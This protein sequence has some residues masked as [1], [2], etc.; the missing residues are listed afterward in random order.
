MASLLNLK[1]YHPTSVKRSLSNE[2]KKFTIRFVLS[3]NERKLTIH[4]NDKRIECKNKRKQIVQSVEEIKSE[5]VA[6]E[7]PPQK[8]R[9][10]NQNLK[11]FDLKSNFIK[12]GLTIND[13]NNLL[14]TIRDI[15]YKGDID[16]KSG[17]RIPF[18]LLFK[19]PPH[20][21]TVETWINEA[22]QNIKLKN[23][24]TGRLVKYLLG[25][26]TNNEWLPIEDMEKICKSIGFRNLDNKDNVRVNHSQFK[27]VK[28]PHPSFNNFPM[29]NEKPI[30]YRL[31]SIQNKLQ[32]SAKHK[33]YYRSALST[34]FPVLEISKEKQ[35]AR[36]HPIWLHWLKFQKSKGECQPGFEHIINDINF[37][38]KL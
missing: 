29:R 9:K 2:I 10:I 8:K 20:N 22:N 27:L 1:D 7:T 19:T 34:V 31:S 32:P 37:L 38:I 33:M 35:Y 23:T 28:F 36:L 26:N 16:N 17:Q 12:L 6:I 4:N 13:P 21:K 30:H 18:F 11:E 14:K 15:E 24:K 3:S 25:L 5:H